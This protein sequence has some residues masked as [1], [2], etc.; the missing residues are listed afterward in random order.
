VATATKSQGKTSFVKKFLQN[1]PQANAKAV[2]QAWTAAGMKG[3][4]S[5]PI[6]SDVR[7]QLGLVGTQPGKTRT[8]GRAK[9]VTRVS[10]TASTP[11]KAMFVKEFLIDNPQGNVRSVNNA[12]QAAG[13]DGAISKTVVFK[14]KAAMGLT[15]D[16]RGSTNKP[17]IS[18]TGKNP[19]TTRK[20]TTAAESVRSRSSSGERTV[21]LD[22]L[23]AE[24]D[25]LI[26]KAM[27]IG[28]LAE[29]EESLRRTRRLLYRALTRG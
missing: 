5:H 17:K 6:V 7:K 28:D 8:A 12:W 16:I 11:G 20:E 2:N 26:F 23:E 1:N 14:V 27:A 29:I 3:T 10:K 18:T 21:L 24:I 19:G 9:S 22:D 25:R 15:G 13:F 4:I